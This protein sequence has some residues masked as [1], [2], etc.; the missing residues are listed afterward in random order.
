MVFRDHLIKPSGMLEQMGQQLAK[1]LAQRTPS[2]IYAS[3]TSVKLNK[4]FLAYDVINGAVFTRSEFMSQVIGLMVKLDSLSMSQQVQRCARCDN[5][6]LL[7]D[8]QN[9]ICISVFVRHNVN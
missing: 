2:V 3:P 6:T 8:I 7:H 4:L 1:R 9:D 5:K